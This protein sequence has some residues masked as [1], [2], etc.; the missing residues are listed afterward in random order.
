MSSLPS[1]VGAVNIYIPGFTNL[2]NLVNSAVLPRPGP[3]PPFAPAAFAYVRTVNKTRSGFAGGRDYS[4]NPTTLATGSFDQHT[5]IRLAS[6]SKFLGAVGFLKLVDKGTLNLS[7]QLSTYISNFSSTRVLQA[8]QPT[9]SYPLPNS[10]SATLGSAVVTVTHASHPFVTGQWIGVQGAAA[11]QGI[12]ASTLNNVVQITVVDPNTYQFTNVNNT[13]ATGTSG[14]SEG[15]LSITIVAVPTPAAGLPNPTQTIWL[16]GYYYYTTVPLVRPIQLHHVITHQLGY[17]YGLP[18]LSIAF[19]FASNPYLRS[20]QAGIFTGTLT[21]A[22]IPD[23]AFPLSAGGVVAWAQALAAIPLLFQPGEGFSY[24]P[25]ISILGAVIERAEVL[26]GTSRSLQTYMQQ[27]VFAPCGMGDTAFFLANTPT[28]Q[29]KLPRVQTLYLEGTQVR[30]ESIPPLQ[31]LADWFYNP[32]YTQTLCLLDA[33]LFSTVHDY[34]AFLN[35]VRRNWLLDSGLLLL[36]PP[37]A[38]WLSSNQCQEW[39]AYEW[40]D[41]WSGQTTPGQWYRWGGG[42]GVYTGQKMNPAATG[43]SSRMIGWESFF[44]AKFFVDL[45]NQR[46]SLVGTQC[47]P[48]EIS[49]RLL[50]RLASVSLTC[51]ESAGFPPESATSEPDAISSA[52]K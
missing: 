10:L 25:Q 23:P 52:P 34:A 5:I 37:M 13:L 15:G 44:Q 17:C 11:V 47:I 3:N 39:S 36:S 19:G 22:A 49:R 42:V 40:T 28:D 43:G 51:F 18:E 8:L 27:E 35:V 9:A 48:L 24:G 45:V 21:P 41:Q 26:Y 12:S 7:E 4:T 20:I 2:G 50:D 38:V 31:Y 6:L 29:A 16:T 30:V 14:A 1:P 46:F 32:L 33:G